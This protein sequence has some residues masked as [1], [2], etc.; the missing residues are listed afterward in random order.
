M[1][2]FVLVFNKLATRSKA[3]SSSVYPMERKFAWRAENSFF[4]F[5]SNF[6]HSYKI[7]PFICREKFLSSPFTNGATI[8]ISKGWTRGSTSSENSSWSKSFAIA[9]LAIIRLIETLRMFCCS[10]KVEMYRKTVTWFGLHFF[11]LFV[12]VFSNSFP[13][14]TSS[15]ISIF[16]FKFKVFWCAVF[17]KLNGI[18]SSCF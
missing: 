14:F 2:L 1:Q 11:R 4:K 8:C 7:F 12:Q 13:S 5:P 18:V 17:C 6:F 16:L 10:R 9:V 15:N 3:D